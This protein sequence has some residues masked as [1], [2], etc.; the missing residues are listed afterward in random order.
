VGDVVER[1]RTKKRDSPIQ[2]SLCENEAQV[3]FTRKLGFLAVPQVCLAIAITTGQD[4]SNFAIGQRKRYAQH[5]IDETLTF[6]SMNR[7]LL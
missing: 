5:L 1:A 6:K 7:G 3:I 4:S 2:T